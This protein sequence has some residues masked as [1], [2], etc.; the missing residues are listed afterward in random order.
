MRF[1]FFI[2]I[3][4]TFTG[5]TEITQKIPIVGKRLLDLVDLYH[6]VQKHGGFE[7]VKIKITYKLVN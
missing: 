1:F 7:K 6:L 2:R 4:F 5:D 3:F